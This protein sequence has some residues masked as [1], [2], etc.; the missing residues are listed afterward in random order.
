MTTFPAYCPHCQT[1][2]P[3]RGIQAGFGTI[4][5]N[6]CKTN[7]PVCGNTEAKVSNGVYETAFDAVRLVTGPD[8]TRL[9][10]EALKAV[11]ERLRAGEISKEQALKEADVISPKYAALLDLFLKNGLPTLALLVAIITLYL[12]YDSGQSSENDA[13]KLLEAVTEQ[14]F[15]MKDIA[16]EQRIERE[17]QTPSSTKTESKL[18]S[19]EDKFE[20]HV[21]ISKKRRAALKKRRLEFGRARTH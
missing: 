14:T 8:S 20:R 10:L 7:C 16:N 5:F 2:F 15:V 4:T 21:Q 18:S 3:F 9:M 19:G 11:A 13:Q 17:R 12:Q 1:I 6:D